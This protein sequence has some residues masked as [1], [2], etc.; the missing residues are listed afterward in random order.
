MR[1]GYSTSS[2]VVGFGFEIKVH[3]TDSTSPDNNNAEQH[4]I[5]LKR[6]GLELRGRSSTSSAK[7]WS[8]PVL[9]TGGK[10][11][12]GTVSGSDRIY[13]DIRKFRSQSGKPVI[14]FMESV[15]ASGGYYTSVACEK[16]IAEPTTVTGSIGVIAKYFVLEELLESKLGIKPVTV[17][18][19][20]RKDWPSSTRMPDAE[21]LKYIDD[22]VIQP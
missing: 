14:A 4:C 12:G 17:K 3:R 11:G 21:E 15:A 1:T 2:G 13:N 8:L 20:K 22:K 10:L 19:G 5:F 7:F 6:Y 16:I 9:A 18:S